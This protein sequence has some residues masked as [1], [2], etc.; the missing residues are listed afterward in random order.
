MVGTLIFHHGGQNQVTDCILLFI[1][2]S[3]LQQQSV[4][5]WCHANLLEH[6][7]MFRGQELPCGLSITTVIRQG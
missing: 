1:I 5:L 6:R 2:S 4:V 7:C 3:L